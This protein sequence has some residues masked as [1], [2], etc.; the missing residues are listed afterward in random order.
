[1]NTL[2]IHSNV[3]CNWLL[4]LIAAQKH[5][6]RATFSVILSSKMVNWEWTKTVLGWKISTRSTCTHTFDH[7][8]SHLNLA[9]T[10]KCAGRRCGYVYSAMRIFYAS[11][12]ICESLQPLWWFSKQQTLLF[13]HL[14]CWMWNWMPLL[15]GCVHLLH[16]ILE[17]MYPELS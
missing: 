4:H 17:N 11:Q 10:T 12:A 9:V 5:V 7:T 1:M 8:V 15:W 6:S 2:L 14:F 13:Y 3:Y 16:N